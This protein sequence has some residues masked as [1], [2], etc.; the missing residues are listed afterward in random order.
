[1]PVAEYVDEAANPI[2]SLT[3]V[4]GEH[5]NGL[6]HRLRTEFLALLHPRHWGNWAFY[7]YIFKY[8]ATK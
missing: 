2:I 1:M 6:V 3:T 5:G 8:P 7:E 4:T